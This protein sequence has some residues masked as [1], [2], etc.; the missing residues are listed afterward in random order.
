MYNLGYL[1]V[2][3]WIIA[4]GEMHVSVLWSN[5]TQANQPSCLRHFQFPFT[6]FGFILPIKTVLSTESHIE[7]I[8]FI[9]KFQNYCANVSSTK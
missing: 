2:H 5:D 7:F 4:V 9:E 6:S 8:M 3:N 1:V